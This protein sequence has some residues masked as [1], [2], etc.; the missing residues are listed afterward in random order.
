MGASPQTG[1]QANAEK[2][3]CT[4]TP[5]EQNA[6]QNHN[7]K[8]GDKS[9]DSMAKFKYLGTLANQNCIHEEIKSRLNHGKDLPFDPESSVFPFHFQ[10]NITFKTYRTIVMIFVSYGCETWC[11][12]LR[13]EHRL[14]LFKNR[15]RPKR[16]DV[17]RELQENAK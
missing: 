10:K 9:F 5:R 6:G 13:E 12:T 15:L 3:K 4:F 1:L 14:W 17:N 2:T 7:I 11:H 8:T 16:D